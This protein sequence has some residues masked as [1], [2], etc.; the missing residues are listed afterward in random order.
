MRLHAACEKK[1]IA[2]SERLEKA[3]PRGIQT[4]NSYLVF[5]EISNNYSNKKGQ[6]NHATQEYKN[7]NIDSMDLQKGKYGYSSRQMKAALEVFKGFDVLAYRPHT[8]NNNISHFH[9]AFQ[10]ENFKQC[11]HSVSHIVEIKVPRIC[12]AIPI[13]ECSVKF[14]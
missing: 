12:P 10:G 11:Q 8:M 14:Q 2:Q 3:K 13:Q 5:I 1:K 4:K 7:M 6:S 9:P